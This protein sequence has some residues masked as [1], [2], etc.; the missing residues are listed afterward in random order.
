M[1]ELYLFRH[2]EAEM[3][4]PAIPDRDRRLTDR[5]KA[6]VYR[7][8]IGWMQNIGQP[9][10]ILH[11]PF[12]RTRQTAEIV[13]EMTTSSLTP[14]PKLVPH[15]NPEEVVRFLLGMESHVLLVTHMPLVGEIAEV[16]TGRRLPFYPGTCAKIL[17]PDPNLAQ[18][19]LD[20]IHHP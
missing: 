6:D 3:P 1:P 12:E 20:W 2:G 11:S 10:D 13:H 4:H 5:G 18:G 8:T 9:F 19:T 15:G 16:V 7:R 17:R 14:E